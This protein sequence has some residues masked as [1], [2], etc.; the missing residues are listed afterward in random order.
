ML[1]GTVGAMRAR[2]DPAALRWI[3]RLSGLVLSV[4]GGGGVPGDDSDRRSERR[5]TGP[6]SAP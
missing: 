3:N 6:W 2:L 4:F 1:T 5:L